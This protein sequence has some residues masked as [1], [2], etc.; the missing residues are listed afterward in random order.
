M[1][2]EFSKIGFGGGCHWCTEA[3]F[4]SLQ[5]VIKVSQGWIA[6]ENEHDA[7]SE[8]VI[9]AYHEAILCPWY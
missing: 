5:G 2:D 7:F 3:V 8:A 4:Q 9:V 6:S 1:K